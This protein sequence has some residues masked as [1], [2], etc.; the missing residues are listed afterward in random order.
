MIST[1]LLVM[2]YLSFISLGLPDSVLGSAWPSMMGDIHAPVWGAGLVQMIVSCGTIVSSL[3]SARLIRRFGTGRLTAF[4]VL[5]TALALLGVSFT[6]HYVWLMLMAV[7]LGLGAGA[8]DA[9]LNNYVAL[10]CAPRHMSCLHCFWGVG[11]TIGPIILSAC[12]GAGASWRAGYWIIGLMQCVL[13]AA[14][15][16]SLPLW[17]REGTQAEERAARVLSVR[18]V[19]SLPGAKQGMATFLCYCAVESTLILWGPTYMVLARGVGEVQAAS[20]GSLVCIGIT[21]GRALS[22]FMTLRFR[23]RQLVQ[24]GQ[25]VLALGLVLMLVPARGAMVAA[26]VLCGLGCAPIYPNIIQDT[27]AN[28]GAE[29]SQA[30]VGVQMASAYIGSTFM[31]T[32]FGALAG[33]LGY[34]ALP[35]VM[36][37]LTAVMAAAF[38]WQKRVR[39]GA[40]K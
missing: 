12:M 36:L 33:V 11:T 26:F 15:L 37:L 5:T 10:H 32:I 38:V 7:P 30:A 20:F 31:P 25:A 9:A 13:S 17:K 21:V 22:G 3:N 29:N 8:V 2:I 39:D 40:G 24:M 28:Y 6:G 4:S 18:E 1:A 14:L 35:A 27:P 34:G 19:L 23:P 16:L